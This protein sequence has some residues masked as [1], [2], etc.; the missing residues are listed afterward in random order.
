[1]YGIEFCDKTLFAINFELKNANGEGGY[2]AGLSPTCAVTDDAGYR[3]W[4]DVTD[5]LLSAALG[6]IANT[7]CSSGG[8]SSGTTHGPV[9]VSTPIN[10]QGRPPYNQW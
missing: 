9:N 4:G 6:H 2:Y 1:M 5:P 10:K 8:V 3:P 7:A